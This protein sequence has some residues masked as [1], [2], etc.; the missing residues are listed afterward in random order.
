M[1]TLKERVTCQES[2]QII[3]SPTEKKEDPDASGWPQI[4]LVHQ[5]S[6]SQPQDDTP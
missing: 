2:N 1:L 6:P 5:D 4:S 3:L